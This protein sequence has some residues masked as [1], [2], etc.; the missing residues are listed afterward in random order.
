MEV[1]RGELGAEGVLMCRRAAAVL[2]R[3]VAG[4]GA[5]GLQV[6][7]VRLVPGPALPRLLGNVDDHAVAVAGQGRPLL[8]VPPLVLA[9]H[10]QEPEDHQ[11][12]EGPDDRQP[13][14]D[15]HK[16]K[17]HVERLLLQGALGLQGHV[18][19][20]PNGSQRDE[21]VVVGVEEAPLLAL[22][23]GGRADAQRPHAGE[24]AHG[25]HVLHGHL[26]VAQATAPLDALQQVAHERVHPLAQALEHDQRQGDAQHRVEHAEGLAR[27]RAGSSVPVTC[28]EEVRKGRGS[29]A[30]SP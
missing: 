16:A 28:R 12:E 7:H 3:A 19:P 25:H 13:H 24:E 1:L 18:V 17:G 2:L 22:G 14:Q 30:G 21:A 6:R 4:T 15:I 11:V 20:E 9:V 26:R 23:E 29:E 10:G 8:G 27:V 5:Y